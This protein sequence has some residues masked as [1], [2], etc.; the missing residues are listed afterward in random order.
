MRYVTALLFGLLLLQVGTGSAQAGQCERKDRVKIRL[1]E[2]VNAW[3]SRGAFQSYLGAQAVCLGR[4]SVVKWDLRAHRDYLWILD[5]HRKKRKR[6][7][8]F[9][10]RA[11]CCKDLGACNPDDRLR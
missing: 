5:D 4:Q 11:Y 6:T 9:V 8:A 7:P 10:R 2:C 3:H 1:A